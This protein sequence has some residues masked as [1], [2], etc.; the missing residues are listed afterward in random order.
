MLD[1]S[2]GKRHV[3]SGSD[4]LSCHFLWRSFSTVSLSTTC[5]ALEADCRAWLQVWIPGRCKMSISAVKFGMEQH[6]LASRWGVRGPW[7]R[8]CA[9]SGHYS[10]PLG[11]GSLCMCL[12]VVRKWNGFVILVQFPVFRTVVISELRFCLQGHWKWEDDIS[13]REQSGGDGPA[14]CRRAETK[15]TQRGQWRAEEK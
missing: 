13:A 11:K 5:A 7:T 9:A 12:T 4:M 6:D 8:P 15:K 10:S 3:C 14:D 1:C 2:C